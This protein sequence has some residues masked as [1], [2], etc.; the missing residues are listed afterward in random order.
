MDEQKS[1]FDMKIIFSKVLGQTI[2]GASGG[3]SAGGAGMTPDEMRNFI[4]E[5]KWEVSCI[6]AVVLTLFC[7]YML[8]NSRSQQVAGLDEDVRQL[9][10]KE[11]PVQ[12]YQNILKEN[13]AYMDSLPPAIA[14][15]KFIT[16]LTAWAGK[17]NIRIRTFEPPQSSN[18]GF[19]RRTLVKMSCTASGFRDALLFLSDIERSKYAVKVVSW[20][21]KTGVGDV[22]SFGEDTVKTD[23]GLSIELSVVTTGLLESGKD[24]KKK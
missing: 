3:S 21:A 24:A 16:E 19:Y 6:S 14:D 9:A 12:D 13:K 4:I 18:E 7:A 1:Q 11:K 17:R 5:R 2:S 20:N 23:S 10:E 8:F 22:E 15:N